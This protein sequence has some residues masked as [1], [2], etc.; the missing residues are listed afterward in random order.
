MKIAQIVP[1]LEARY[2]GPSV[3]VPALSAGL[4]ALGH[5]VNLLATA[6]TPAPVAPPSREGVQA[7]IFPCSWPP[8]VCFSSALRDRLRQLDAEIFHSHGLWLR[9]L[10]YADQAARRRR[11]PHVIS[12]RGMMSGW[13]WRHRAWRK[14]L[15]R[16]FIH[17]GAFEHAAGWHAT[18]AEE[19]DDIRALGFKQP[20]CV[21][22]N[23]TSAPTDQ[24]LADAGAYWRD[25]CPDVTRRPTAVFYSRFHRKKRVLEL[26]D[27]WLERAPADWLLLMV[28]LPDDYTSSQLETYIMRSSGAGRIHV[29]E[30]DDRLPPYAVGS[31]FL[32]PSQSENFGL[33]IADAMAHGLP[34]L[35]TDTTPWT[36]VDTNGAGWCVSWENFPAALLS[37]LAEGPAALA[38]RGALARSYVLKNFSWEQSARTLADFY[39]ELRGAPAS[40]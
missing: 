23:G 38:A 8:A 25:T 40:K 18:S 20:V 37:A 12:P 36:A 29:F 7:E 27:L 33:A 17:P 34:V 31:I 10:Y 1:S 3:S 26:I 35:V 22:P 15:V 2:G 4:A 5:A 13:A 24:A 14:K 39:R 32:L 9:P 19:A 6:P 28:G 21:A 16:H 11:A 30:G